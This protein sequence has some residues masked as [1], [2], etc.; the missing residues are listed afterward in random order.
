MT[1]NDRNLA[2]E[3]HDVFHVMQLARDTELESVIG[4]DYVR[5]DPQQ[6]SQIHRH[7]RSETVLYILEGSGVIV[8]EDT[9]HT[10]V[11]GD[12][13]RIRPGEFHGVRTQTEGLVFISVQSPPILDN[14]TGTLDL[15]PRDNPKQ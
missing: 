11:R 9:D 5:L 12:R 4:A 15:E 3:V 1:V 2:V 8:I 7:N 13:I 14:S 10:V 6:T